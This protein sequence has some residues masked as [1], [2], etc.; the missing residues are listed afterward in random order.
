M[1]EVPAPETLDKPVVPDLLPLLTLADTVVFPSMVVPLIVQGEREVKAI[2]NAVLGQKVVG[3]FWQHRPAEDFDPQAMGQ[4][5]TAAHIARLVRLADGRM[6]LLLQG[7]ARIQIQQ[8]QYTDPYPVARVQVFADPTERSTSLEGLAR[9][10]LSLFQEVVNLAPYLPA[11]IGTTAASL[12]EPGM[13]ADFIAAH[14]NLR[15]EERQAILDTLDVAERLRHVT[16]LLQREKEI[17]E[18]GRKAQQEMSKTQREYVLRQQ[19]EAIRRELGETD[20]R[21]AEVNAL[22]ERLQQA[23]LPEEAR[24]EVERE[25]ERLARMPP[26]APEYVV[27]STYLDWILDLPWQVEH[28]GQPGYRACAAGARRGSL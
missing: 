4:T 1:S 19:M 26:G 18:I 3:L 27:A 15:L 24:K 14:L 21:Q 25:L 12:S 13:L 2:E 6:Q 8:L 11:E 22:R 10:A 23:Q 28:G 7:L 17:L 20:E 5:G 9:G 16:E